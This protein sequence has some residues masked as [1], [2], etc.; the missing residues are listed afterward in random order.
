VL[1]VEFAVAGVSCIGLNGG[2]QQE[3]ERYWNGIVGNGGQECQCGWCKDRSG[4]PG[5]SRRAC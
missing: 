2:P 3:T 1:T 4:V 5:K